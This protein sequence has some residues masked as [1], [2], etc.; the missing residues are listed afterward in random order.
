MVKLVLPS[1]VTV[2]T[3]TVHDAAVAALRIRTGEEPLRVATLTEEELAA[4]VRAARP[5]MTGPH[6]HTGTTSALQEVRRLRRALER[7]ASTELMR[8]SE[9]A[10]VEY[11]FRCDYAQRILDGGQP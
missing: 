11:L 10:R 8:D 5:Y 4:T 7:L 9:N 1:G 6:I 3:E 2:E